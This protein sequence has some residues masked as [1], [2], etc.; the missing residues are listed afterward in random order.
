MQS[1]PK[2]IAPDMADQSPV[3]EQQR[4]RKV[5]FPGLKVN[6][7]QEQNGKNF[8]DLITFHGRIDS[9]N[10]YKLNRQAHNN[11]FKWDKD[12]LIG[13]ADLEHINSVGIAILFSIF[14]RQKESNKQVAIGGMH[15]FLKN[16][17]ELV[18]FPPQVLILDSLAAAKQALL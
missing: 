10:A 2:N 7:S 12:I 14:H 6:I 8:I 17:F 18:H 16:V 11:F 5:D 4:G 1:S 9:Q 13:L 3:L 15:P